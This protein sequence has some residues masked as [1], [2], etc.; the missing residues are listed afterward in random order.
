MKI[1]HGSEGVKEGV[2]WRKQRGIERSYQA[3][4]SVGGKWYV[5]CERQCNKLGARRPGIERHNL[6]RGEERGIG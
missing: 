1:E 5:A 6:R 4:K 3:A 2:S